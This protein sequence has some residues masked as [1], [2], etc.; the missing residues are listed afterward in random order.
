MAWLSKGHSDLCVS[1]PN[2]YVLLES[3][4]SSSTGCNMNESQLKPNKT[5]SFAKPD[6]TKLAP[7]AREH[8]QMHKCFCKRECCYWHH[9]GD[10]FDEKE[11][12]DQKEKPWVNKVSPELPDTGEEN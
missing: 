12:E 7:W 1:S 11:H 3:D 4:L 5:I 8:A 9:P 6:Y 10:Q 2:Q